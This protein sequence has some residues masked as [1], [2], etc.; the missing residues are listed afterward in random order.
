MTPGQ[1]VAAARRVGGISQRELSRLSGVPQPSISR[2]EGGQDA[3]VGTVDRL[4]R[5]L[6]A[7]LSWLPTGKLTAAAAAERISR[8]LAAD[9]G[10]LVIQRPFWQLADDLATSAPVLRAALVVAPP[11]PT[12]EA[13]YDAAISALVEYRLAQVGIEAPEWAH[14]PD[15]VADPEWLVCERPRLEPFVRAETPEPFGRRGVLISPD[16]L[17][18]V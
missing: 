12:G 7:Q 10:L 11:S 14:D 17:V 5:H 13:R 15:R 18:S 8:H 4:L 3:T 1:A 2:I 9:R 16:D 6:G